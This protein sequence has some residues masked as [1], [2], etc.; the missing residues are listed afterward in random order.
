MIYYNNTLFFFSMAITFVFVGDTCTLGSQ[1]T[2]IIQKA[3][4]SIAKRG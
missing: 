2:H 4:I 1:Q 3:D